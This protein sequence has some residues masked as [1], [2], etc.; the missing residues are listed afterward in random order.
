MAKLDQDG[1]RKHGE[2]MAS[3]RTGK[4]SAISCNTVRRSRE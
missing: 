4:Q 1:D 2:L 3:A